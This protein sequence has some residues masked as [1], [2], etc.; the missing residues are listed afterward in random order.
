MIPSMPDDST[1][2]T[3][4]SRDTPRWRAKFLAELAL[5][6]NVRLACEVAAI[7][8]K[9]AYNHRHA[10]PEFAEQ[11]DD[12]IEAA[13]DRMEEAARIRAVE[14]VRR[15]VW[16]Q[17]ERVGEELEYSDAMLALMLKA[18]RPE[19]YRENYDPN[20]AAGGADKPPGA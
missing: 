12:A 20:R 5:R 16:Y 6:A 8:R 17:G 11:W 13:V 4:L 19:K 14:G 1:K 2:S 3:L 9:T 15:G 18:N 7:D 10:D